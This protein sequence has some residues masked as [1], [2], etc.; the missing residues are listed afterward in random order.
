MSF[1]LLT[2][3]S[4]YYMGVSLLYVEGTFR[5]LELPLIAGSLGS[6]EGRTRGGFFVVSRDSYGQLQR[7]RRGRRR[8]PS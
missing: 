6:L 4:H 1:V 7:R 3:I 2:A 5:P 8:R